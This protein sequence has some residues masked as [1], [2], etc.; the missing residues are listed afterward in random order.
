MENFTEAF[1][2]AER[3]SKSL[4]SVIRGRNDTIKL[5]LTGLYAHVHV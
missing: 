4:T 2:I 1:Q 3:L 5:V